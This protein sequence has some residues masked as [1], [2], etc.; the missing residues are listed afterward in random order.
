M[1][2]ITNPAID[3]GHLRRVFGAHPSGVTALAAEIDGRPHGMVASTF[4]SVSLHPALVSVCVAH[5][6]T[7]WPTLRSAPH[8][9]V[10]VLSAAQHHA[11]RLL[12]ARGVDRFADV[13][14][15]A[16][17]RGA[18]LLDGAAAWLETSVEDIVTAGDH[19]IVV[20]AVH[21]LDLDDSRQPLVFHGSAFR[22]L[23]S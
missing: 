10:S 5:S 14:W 11:G 20:L 16:T 23:A 6:S 9:G 15:H 21:D 4:T 19:D 22:R 18:V 8:L 7:T 2:V 3:T 17:T 13:D 1:S 12:S